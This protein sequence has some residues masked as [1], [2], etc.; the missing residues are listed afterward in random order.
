MYAKN[1]QLVGYW[2]IGIGKPSDAR[3]MEV[4][5]MYDKNTQFVGHW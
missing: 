4:Q 5:L 3:R 2:Q 1:I